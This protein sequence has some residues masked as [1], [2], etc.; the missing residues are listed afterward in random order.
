VAVLWLLAIFGV[1]ALGYSRSTRFKSLEIANEIRLAEEEHL[2][3]SGLERASFHCDL[4]L[5]NRESF[6]LMAA[7]GRLGRAQR[8]LMWYP[9]HETYPL[10]MEGQILYVR[11][12][13]VG[14][15]MGIAAMTPERWSAVLAA[16]GIED[17][18]AR[19]EIAD[20]VDD[21]QDEDDL[22][23][24][25]GAEQDYY[26]GLEPAYVC[27]NAPLEN[28][29]ELLLVRGVTAELYHGTEE[30]PGLVHFLDVQGQAERLDIN[31]AHPRAFAIVQGLSPRDAAAL[32]TLRLDM[33]FTSMTEASQ[34]LDLETAGELERFF[35]VL[36]ESTGLVLRISRDPDPGPDSRIETRKF[37]Q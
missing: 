27:K 35:H 2:L 11:V 33:P 1:V 14:A 26:S 6:L 22:V 7:A 29:E 23:H 4:Y 5:R 12:E 31:S 8:S 21:W 36:P 16:C 24:A 17:E 19:R 9:R 37:V 10:D 34:L 20:A 13:P 15:R 18:R 28:L 30:H 25:G 32:V 3:W